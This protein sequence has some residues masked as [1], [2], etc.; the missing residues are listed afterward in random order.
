MLQIDG[1]YVDKLFPPQLLDITHYKYPDKF[2]LYTEAC[3]MSMY[4]F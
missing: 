4:L 3:V 1:W 2:I